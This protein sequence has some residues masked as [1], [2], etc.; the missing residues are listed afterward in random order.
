MN[1]QQI[2]TVIFVLSQGFFLNGMDTSKTKD[3]KHKQKNFTDFDKTEPIS[4]SPQKKPTGRVITVSP[5]DHL[6]WAWNYN[7]DQEKH[8]INGN[9]LR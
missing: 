9:S 5:T 8:S 3:K 4:I 7:K 6:F 1:K 2:F